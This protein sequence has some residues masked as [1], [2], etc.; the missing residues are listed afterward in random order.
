MIDL[1]SPDV[2]IKVL[3]GYLNGK[4][5]RFATLL[6]IDNKIYIPC[7]VEK[8]ES[9]IGHNLSKENSINILKSRTKN[10]FKDIKNDD[11]EEITI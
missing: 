6:I 4:K 10:V 1:Y 2:N 3:K 5:S 9:K 11:V 8:K 7:L